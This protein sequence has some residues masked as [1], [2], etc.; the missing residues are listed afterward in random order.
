MP[1]RSSSFAATVATGATTGGNG[2]GFTGGGGGGG[3]GCGTGLDR[4]R[5]F[6][7]RHR[8]VECALPLPLRAGRRCFLTQ[9]AP[10]PAASWSGRGEEHEPSRDRLD[11]NGLSRPPAATHRADQNEVCGHSCVKRA[12][13]ATGSF[14]ASCAR[15]RACRTAAPRCAR[16]RSRS[17][18]TA[19][20]ACSRAK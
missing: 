17:T 12:R 1:A 20:I 9:A 11:A 10:A 13:H 18:R 3:S 19:A 5:R 7:D 4:R 2:S 8:A 6:A 16:R 15:T 14:A